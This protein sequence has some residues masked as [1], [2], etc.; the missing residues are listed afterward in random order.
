[1]SI[2]TDI[3]PTSKYRSKPLDRLG[4][5]ASRLIA[6][7]GFAGIFVILPLGFQIHVLGQIQGGLADPEAADL[8]DLLVAGGYGL[9]ALGFLCSGLTV[10]FWTY[11]AAANVHAVHPGAME[12]RPGW[13]VGWNFVPIWSLWKPYQA[14]K[15]IWQASVSP[16]PVPDMFAKWWFGWV[17]FNLIS[18]GSGRM[19]DRATE[20]GDIDKMQMALVL[21]IV[22]IA[23]FMMACYFFYRIVCDITRAQKTMA[24]STAHVFE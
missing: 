1:M 12:I 17:G 4:W 8:S 3:G 6:L 7:N 16:D 11:R 9:L 2:A 22:E 18:N 21:T 19:L 15:Q 10:L 23:L 20:N 5:W 24:S 14:M 13:A